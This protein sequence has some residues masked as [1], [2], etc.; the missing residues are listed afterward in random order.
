MEKLNPNLLP[1]N[2]QKDT[3]KK[4][5][6]IP[7]PKSVVEK[8]AE[9]IDTTAAKEEQLK[10]DTVDLKKVRETLGIIQPEKSD[11]QDAVIDTTPERIQREFQKEFGKSIS[12]L[13]GEIQEFEDGLKLNK[14]NR[15]SF[16]SEGL[17]TAVTDESVDFQK[18]IQEIDNLQMNLKKDFMPRNDRDRLSIEPYNFT[19]TIDSLDRLKGSLIGLRSKIDKRPVTDNETDTKRLSES[20]TKAINTA[21]RKMDDM[22]EI[23]TALRRYT[24][25]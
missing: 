15:I 1:E 24:G 5:E 18:T 4:S 22:E 12:R 10:K 25:R 17:R 13:S 2:L 9:V 8:P 21:R 23:Q 20:L 11:T 19:R 7:A 3:E 14:F 6:E 16:Q